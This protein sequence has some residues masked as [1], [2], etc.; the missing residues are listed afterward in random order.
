MVFEGHSLCIRCLVPQR[1]WMLFFILSLKKVNLFVCVD[2][3]FHRL[4]KINTAVSG[5][6]M[7]I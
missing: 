3:V 4:V 1:V 2:L 6:Q 5:T 7:Y